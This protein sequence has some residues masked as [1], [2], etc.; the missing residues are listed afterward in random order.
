MTKQ[1]DV[2][3]ILAGTADLRTLLESGAGY[4]MAVESI[5][6]YAIFA[7]DP[8]GRVASWNPG[9]EH[10][11]G[12]GEEEIFGRDATV[13]FTPEEAE[14]GVPQQELKT[15]AEKGRASD[16]R[17]HVRKDGSYF[18]ASGITT[19]LRDAKGTL[20]GFIKIM[21]DRTDRK[22]LEEELHNRAEAL[23]RADREKDEFLAVLA[24]ELR[25]PL[26]PVFYA[27][28]LL[29]EKPLEDPQR[30]YLRRIVDRQMRRLARLIDDLLDIS[31]IRTGK[32]E[33]RK[34]RI[35]LSGAVD[36]A[37]DIVRPLCEDRGIELTVALPP[38]PVWLKADPTRFEQV[39]SNLL[40]NA[41]KF[42]EDKG[43]IS[44]A[45]ER[46]GREIVVR[47]KD[48]G[49]G[50]APDLLP[51]IFDL[52][53]QGDSSLDRSRDGLGIGL[54]LSQ[55]LV[56]LHGGTIEARSEGAGTGSEF[57]VRL[58]M[59]LETAPPDAE[60]AQVAGAASQSLRILV[61]D[62]SEDTA[63]TMGTLLEMSG[64]T[65]EIA[66]SGPAALEAAATFRPDVVLLD[67]GLPGLDGYQVAE[68]LRED[69]TM[70]GVT[71]IAASGYGQEE[72]RRRSMEAGIDRHLV[73]P[74]DLKELQ[75][76][77][78]VVERR[79]AG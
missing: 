24:H 3:G 14:R 53:I 78:A 10:L 35:E 42:T 52:F 44:I 55:K 18:F 11:L 62:D 31:R 71:L 50:I 5:H 23:S 4:R 9:A 39:L 40:S 2:V 41:V 46:E 22:R 66:H 56:E 17:W 33:L 68:R 27:L 12:Y 74:V 13:F 69:P 26:A 32:V 43:S 7:M 72:D 21:R 51:R 67:I 8:E 65:V 79:R 47:V 16:D 76:L 49:V 59:L 70:Q 45:A 37:V 48:T 25:N 1:T 34:E 64:H 61:V 58:P 28:R 75:E 15:A 29:D 30:W 20:Q 77:L 19:S 36:H 38:E 63:E 54:T 6:D 60:A 73:K 57:V